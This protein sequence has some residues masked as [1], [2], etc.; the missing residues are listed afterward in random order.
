MDNGEATIVAFNNLKISSAQSIEGEIFMAEISNSE[1][2]T[3]K[4]QVPVQEDLFYH[5][6][7]P[8]EKPYLIGAK[9]NVCGYVSFPKLM[10]CP[11]CVKKDT[12]EEIHIGGKGKIDTFSICY[13]ALPGFEAP[14]I[15]AYINLEEGARIWSLITGVEPSDEVLKIG[16]DV[17]LVIG[18]VRE[19]TEGNE[20]M[21]YQ[22]KPVNTNQ[23][24]K[25]I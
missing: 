12:M 20:I 21:S 22:F 6:P 8:E 23:E 18:K 10:I 1:S 5:P 3:Q 11:R 9:C 14:S 17:E 13:A 4:K 16:M 15:Q 25:I 2:A 19:D 24:R 7:S